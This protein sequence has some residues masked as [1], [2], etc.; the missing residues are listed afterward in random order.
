MNNIKYKI[1]N[2]TTNWRKNKI[3]RINTLWYI[4]NESTNF[5]TK[6]TIHTKELKN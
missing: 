6:N 4:S 1:W 3:I 2:S 5:P